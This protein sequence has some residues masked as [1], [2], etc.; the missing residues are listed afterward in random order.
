MYYVISFSGCGIDSPLQSRSPGSALAMAEEAE[1]S[2]C[3]DVAIKVPGGNSLSISQFAAEFV[4][5]QGRRADRHPADAV[6]RAAI[7]AGPIS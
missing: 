2:G 7:D 6:A 4:M 3:E 5:P 1:R